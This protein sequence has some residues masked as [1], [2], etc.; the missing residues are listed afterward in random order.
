M[1]FSKEYFDVKPVN[2]MQSIACIID[3]KK[4]MYEVWENNET[5]YM[6]DKIITQDKN[7]N[8]NTKEYT[9][10]NDVL[11]AIKDSVVS[12]GGRCN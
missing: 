12:R 4:Y 1:I 9:N 11:N 10:F 7:L 5:S 2:E 8:I 6:I 3:G